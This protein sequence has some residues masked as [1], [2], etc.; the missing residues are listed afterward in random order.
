MYRIQRKRR[1]FLF[2]VLIFLGAFAVG[3][4]A[5]YGSIKVQQSRRSEELN[6]QEEAVM[7]YAA[8]DSAADDRPASVVLELSEPT[9]PPQARYFVA[10]SDG[11]VCVFTLDSEGVQRFSHK[12]S[13]VLEALP[14]VDQKLFEEGIYLY[15]EQ[16]LLELTE[17][18]SS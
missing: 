10:E 12:L 1:G 2:Y 7:P 15:S 4:G 5:G 14:A 8:S 6:M 13:I 11:T 16:E 3:L 17:D 9:P 18:F